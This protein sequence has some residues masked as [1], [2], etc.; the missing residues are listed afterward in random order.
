M[1]DEFEGTITV[2]ITRT[3]EVEVNCT[4]PGEAKK[5]VLDMYNSGDAC[6]ELSPPAF[7]VIAMNP[8]KKLYIYGD[9]FDRFTGPTRFEDTLELELM[10]DGHRR[11]QD[12]ENDPDELDEWMEGL[13]QSYDYVNAI[14]EVSGMEEADRLGDA[15]RGEK[16][17]INVEELVFGLGSTE[18]DAKL[19]YLEATKN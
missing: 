19:A 9:Y 10:E 2:L 1:A 13:D 5:A 7:S 16:V 8:T 11:W 12:R 4:T 17:E 14:F 18:D 15:L 3:R 6:A